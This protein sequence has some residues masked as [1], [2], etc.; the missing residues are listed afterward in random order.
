[1]HL[2]K[3]PIYFRFAIVWAA[4]ISGC[5][6]QQPPGSQLAAEPSEPPFSNSEPDR[7][8]AIVVQSSP[9]GS[10]RFLIARDGE[11]WRIDAEY[12]GPNQTGSLHVDKKD[13]ILDFAK[14]VYS[15]Y[16]AGHGFDER[17]GMV[18]EISHGLLNSRE[19]ANYQLVGT[20]GELT[21]YK[22]TNSKGKEAI[23]IVDTVKRL[24]V[25]KEIYNTADGGS[26][27]EMTITLEDLRLEP[28]AANFELPKDFK[29]VPISEMKKI[30]SGGK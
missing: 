22:M 10:V 8:Q 3:V 2:L 13:Y 11:Q 25:K 14:K 27:L 19:V 9:A 29:Q 12:G 16:T 5:S 15:E 4:L 26:Q 23:I 20:E 1:M 6:V 30:L 21:R 18:E 17:P 7:Y 28:D 24:P